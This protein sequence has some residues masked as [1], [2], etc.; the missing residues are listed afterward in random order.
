MEKQ[1]CFSHGTDAGV[2]Y[3]SNIRSNYIIEHEYIKFKLK[4]L[5]LKSYK[6]SEKNIV[7]FNI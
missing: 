4:V 2:Y 6:Y 5:N 1:R 7:I 3:C